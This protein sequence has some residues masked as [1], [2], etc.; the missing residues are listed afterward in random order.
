MTRHGHLPKFALYDLRG[1][2]LWSD[3]VIAKAARVKP[4]PSAAEP[5]PNKSIRDPGSFAAVF[6]GLFD[7]DHGAAQESYQDANHQIRRAIMEKRSSVHAVVAESLVFESNFGG[8]EAHVAHP[9][10]EAAKRAQSIPAWSAAALA[11]ETIKTNDPA[12]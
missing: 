4:V 11:C 2:I 6:I 7:Q 9:G 5:R 8:A 1:A 3:S 12:A 10:Q